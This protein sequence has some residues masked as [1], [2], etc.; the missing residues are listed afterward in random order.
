MWRAAAA[1]DLERWCRGERNA[2]LPCQ[3][4]PGSA[5]DDAE[6][7]AGADECTADLVDGAVSTPGDDETGAALSR[8]LA[9][10]ARIAAAARHRHLHRQAVAAEDV[11]GER[12]AGIDERCRRGPGSG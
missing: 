5:R 1:H 11:A 4:I 7:D 10:R 8:P 6:R 3:A 9:E 2:E 12:R